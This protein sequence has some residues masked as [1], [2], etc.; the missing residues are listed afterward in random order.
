MQA[1]TQIFVEIIQ[2][3]VSVAIPLLEALAKII[4]PTI[5]IIFEAVAV[6]FPVVQW[7]FQVLF[8]ALEPILFIVVHIVSW[9]TSLFAMAAM[10]QRQLLSLNDDGGVN[11]NFMRFQQEMYGSAYDSG[12][13]YWSS[14]SFSDAKKRELQMIN[15]R[16]LKRPPKSFDYY[17]TIH[18]P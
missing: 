10:M 18:R 7:L 6:V 12:R 9:F 11:G 2:A 4:G 15:R 1:L 8:Y 5:N 17:W 16:N 13:K 3:L 14:P